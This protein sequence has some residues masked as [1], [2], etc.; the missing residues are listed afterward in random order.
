MMIKR[1]LCSLAIGL[2]AS[3]CASAPDVD[4]VDAWTDWSKSLEL[5]YTKGPMAIMHNVN[6][7]YLA[8][9]QTAYV[10][11]RGDRVYLKT[12]AGPNDELLWRVRFEKGD[13][14]WT[15]MSDTQAGN[16]DGPVDDAIMIDDRYLLSQNFENIS[17]DERQLR[18]F[19][20]DEKATPNFPGLE[21]FRYDIAGVI[22]AKFKPAETIEPVILDTERGLT[23]RF[24]KL[25]DARF[26]YDGQAYQ[27]PMFSGS[28][29]T[30][31]VESLFTGLTDGTSGKTS[32]GVGRYLDVKISSY[33]PKD[34][35][36][37]FNRLYNPYCA[38][39]DAY[40]CPVMPTH[41]DAALP[42]GEKYTETK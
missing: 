35:T 8:E 1:L 3:A 12:E 28:N 26:E 38:R 18:L 2:M 34:L 19:L 30:D 42:Y 4:P 37:D 11:R 29:Q 17:L 20:F 31:Q 22:P 40:N 24:Y 32:Y 13:A 9:G 39:T 15:P 23:K 10:F 14:L 27:L 5:A 33:P 41:L 6:Y 36:L 21:F 16:D 7:V 25:G